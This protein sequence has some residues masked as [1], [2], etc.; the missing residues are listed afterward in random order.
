MLFS[1]K[2]DRNICTGKKNSVF[3]ETEF[4]IKGL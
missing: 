2:K 1:A 4:M 3:L